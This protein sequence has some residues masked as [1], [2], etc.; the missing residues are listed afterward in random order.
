[1][2]H[3]SCPEKETCE[4]S[5]NRHGLRV[6][7]SS[8]SNPAPVKGRIVHDVRGNAVWEWARDAAEL[9]STTTTGLLRSLSGATALTLEPDNSVADHASFDPYN[10]RVKSTS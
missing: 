8:N 10:R 6:V 9:D 2:Q 1:M 7:Q 5:K 4:M 3:V